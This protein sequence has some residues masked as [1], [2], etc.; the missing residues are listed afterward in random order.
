MKLL[1]LTVRERRAMT[2]QLRCYV[3]EPVD[4]TWGRLRH[5]GAR[6]EQLVVEMVS[7]VQQM[8]ALFECVWPAALE[9]VQQ[10]FKSQTWAP[11]AEPGVRR[12]P[13]TA[14]GPSSTHPSPPEPFTATVVARQAG[15]RGEACAASRHPGTRPP[16]GP[17]RHPE[18]ERTPLSQ[19]IDPYRA[20][21]KNLPIKPKGSDGYYT[22][23][24]RRMSCNRSRF[25]RDRAPP[26]RGGSG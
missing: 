23:P 21:E 14:P 10:P 1:Y 8:R 7:Q 2:L 9:A 25:G 24:R 22:M 3:P 4:E 18:H 5:L 17:Y 11:P 19:V 16:G 6:R 15:G 26:P 12:S 20:D 13:P